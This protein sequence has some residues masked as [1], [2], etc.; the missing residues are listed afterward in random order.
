MD[1]KSIFRLVGSVV[2]ACLF[3]GAASA[4][5]LPQSTVPLNLSTYA[6]GLG[7]YYTN[8]YNPFAES[9]TIDSVTVANA[10]YSGSLQINYGNYSSI[11]YSKGTSTVQLASPITLGASQ[12]NGG[13]ISVYSSPIQYSGLEFLANGSFNTNYPCPVSG[14]CLIN[15]KA[16]VTWNRN[17]PTEISAVGGAN[18]LNVSGGS[19]AAGT[20][21]TQAAC[22]GST[23]E[24][25]TLTPIGEYYHLVAKNSGECLNVPGNSTQTG[26]QLIQWGCQ[27]SSS[28][29]DQW[30]VTQ[31]ADGNY[32]IVSRSSSL[33]V[34]MQAGGAV[35][36]NACQLS[37][38]QQNEF[39][40][41][42]L[43]AAWGPAYTL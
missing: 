31:L 28:M 1:K 2:G 29:N 7:T 36:Q 19:T 17:L 41:P 3:S 27:G 15:A 33:C 25:W 12:V 32:Q 21:I 14:G 24:T 34:E 37:P 16:T 39:K 38:S 43:P 8:A 26:A 20:G 5:L 30:S 10:D 40:L 18:C 11:S 9:V 4:T 35:V 6:G 13:K 42:Q 22:Q 23:S